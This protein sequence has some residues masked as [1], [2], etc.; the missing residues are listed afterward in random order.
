MQPQEDPNMAENNMVERRHDEPCKLAE[1]VGQKEHMPDNHEVD[2]T[3]TVNSTEKMSENDDLT[4]EEENKLLQAEED[5]L[6]VID[7]YTE[8]FDSDMENDFC[9]KEKQKNEE[10]TK[11]KEKTKEAMQEKEK[12]KKTVT[13]SKNMDKIEEK[14]QNKTT[15]EEEVNQ[16]KPSPKKVAAELE[17]DDDEDVIQLCDDISDTF[18]EDDAIGSSAGPTKPEISSQAKIESEKARILSEP[19]VK[20]LVIPEICV[21]DEEDDRSVGSQESLS[22][23]IDHC[24]EKAAELISE[25]VENGRGKTDPSKAGGTV[26]AG[27]NGSALNGSNASEGGLYGC[28]QEDP[29]VLK[30]KLDLYQDM[31]GMDYEAEDKTEDGE[32]L[33]V[34][35]IKEEPCSP[36]NLFSEN[37]IPTIELTSTDD[38]VVTISISPKSK[39]KTKQNK[40]SKK[41]KSKKKGST[42]Y[43]DLRMDSS[44]D[45][46]PIVVD[47][48]TVSIDS[49]NTEMH[50]EESEKAKALH[51]RKVTTT[52]EVNG[53]GKKSKTARKRS[54]DADLI[55]PPVK[56]KKKVDPAM[57][58]YQKRRRS[59]GRSASKSSMLSV[60]SV[61]SSIPDEDMVVISANDVLLADPSMIVTG[62]TTNIE[63]DKRQSESTDEITDGKLA[64]DSKEELMH[65]L[66]LKE[67]ITKELVQEVSLNGDKNENESDEHSF[68]LPTTDIALEDMLES[69]IDKEANSKHSELVFH[70]I[71]PEEKFLMDSLFADCEKQS[72][73]VPSEDHLESLKTIMD[74]GKPLVEPQKVTEPIA[75]SYTI[76]DESIQPETVHMQLE[77][78]APEG[79][80]VPDMAKGPKAPNI[81]IIQNYQKYPFQSKPPKKQKLK[82]NNSNGQQRKGR[83]RKKREVKDDTDEEY[84][85]SKVRTRNRGSKPRKRKN[86]KPQLEEEELNVVDQQ[87]HPEDGPLISEHSLPKFDNGDDD[88]DG[89]ATTST[90]CRNMPTLEEDLAMTSSD[91]G[92]T[93]EATSK[94][95]ITTSPSK[96]SS[97]STEGSGG[98]T[99][100]NDDGK[101]ERDERQPIRITKGDKVSTKPSQKRKR[102]RVISSSNSE[103]STATISNSVDTEP[104]LQL[105]AST[106]GSDTEQTAEGASLETTQVAADKMDNL[107]IVISPLTEDKIRKINTPQ[108]S[109]GLTKASQT[110]IS[111][112]TW[113]IDLHQID[114]RSEYFEK[115]RILLNNGARTGGDRSFNGVDIPSRSSLQ[116]CLV[117]SPN[118]RQQ[119]ARPVPDGHNRSSAEDLLFQRA[120][121][122]VELGANN[123]EDR[124]ARQRLE[125]VVNSVRSTFR[126][127]KVK[128]QASSSPQDVTSSTPHVAEP[129]YRDD[130]LGVEQLPSTSR[131]VD[132]SQQSNG[133]SSSLRPPETA[134]VVQR[135]ITNDYVDENSENSD[136]V[137]AMSRERQQIRQN[138]MLQDRFEVP[139]NLNMNAGRVNVGYMPPS[140]AE[141]GQ[142]ETGRP[143]PNPDPRP[144]RVPPISLETQ[145][146]LPSRAELLNVRRTIRNDAPPPLQQPPQLV[147][148]E[149]PP[150]MVQ[151][152]LPEAKYNPPQANAPFTMFGG[153]QPA[154][155]AVSSNSFNRTG[156]LLGYSGLETPSM[157]SGDM[158]S[159]QQQQQLR[160]NPSNINDF[161]TMLWEQ[162]R[163]QQQPIRQQPLIQPPLQ[164]PVAPLAQP[165]VVS[166]PP[167]S[168]NQQ[169]I[170]SQMLSQMNQ[171]SMQPSVPQ[172]TPF[173]PQRA[174]E[175][176]EII[177]SIFG[178]FD[179]LNDRCIKTHCRYPHILP[180]EEEVFQKL[181]M[182][183]RDVIM[184]SYRFVAGRD[185]LFIKYFP[186][187]ASVMG[188]NNMR[189]QLVNTITDCEQS[190][191][192]IQYYKYIVEGLK[193][194][195]TSAVQAV[196]LILEKH[197]KKSFNQIN[198]LIELILDTGEGIPTFLR[199]LEEF[200]HVKDYYYEIPSVNR[201]L[202]FS[203][204]STLPINEL[205]TFVSKLILKVPA[206]AEQFVNTRMLL[207][208]IQKVRLD[209]ALALDVEDIVKKYGSVVMRP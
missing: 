176:V 118:P 202:E 192:P 17:D 113:S 152:F 81:K 161:L 132:R 58:G 199:I 183:S 159:L 150:P 141:N 99:K 180:R 44:E 119:P 177:C 61:L 32:K 185:D 149:V 133:P 13:N 116:R 22:L 191:R 146:G 57:M 83:G 30:L 48:S 98:G 157:F 198:V 121:N 12:N 40:K 49:R 66:D 7:C 62:E 205:A 39:V 38:E 56:K 167:S 103:V 75:I 2:H 122:E 135:T 92:E 52:P 123:T 117:M 78:Y 160:G 3:E 111:G 33:T 43:V 131:S 45:S 158:M 14:P 128:K 76:C 153:F 181:L 72:Q 203:V 35:R 68:P 95:L 186:A 162:F 107:Q 126:I 188:R 115:L 65:S 37:E 59:V 147:L 140:S 15:T 136:N 134:G 189:H 163:Q 6:D 88:D 138:I 124:S 71:S 69:F 197:T 34:I 166:M 27:K 82:D 31:G 77:T 60:T 206:G 21:S 169:P 16:Q 184:A 137:S 26:P 18:L 36:R 173:E 50:S 51:N 148:P 164:P 5:D 46:F 9:R 64:N 144:A 143:L 170:L 139:A 74:D 194:S 1:P 106:I 42:E 53:V 104:E 63:N 105:S 127:P 102:K 85:P 195:G 54:V 101:K 108:K 130:D 89:T 174:N 4:E 19:L 93:F 73:Q 55:E 90:V 196:Q 25:V 112:L 129:V 84:L 24:V 156:S 151:Q 67:A 80:S 125:R 109:K 29:D 110:E 41:R 208:F 20:Q 96:I 165:Q 193:V 190:K 47:S 207:E 172:A 97:S 23:Q 209:P 171:I 11:E 178:C 187:Y 142:L 94:E 175:Q 91:E 87:Q 154:Q 204:I 168:S 79:E 100:L 114:F 145:S 28:H 86:S 120:L 70:S 179:F 200:F 155:F 10:T 182:Q 201:L 8:D